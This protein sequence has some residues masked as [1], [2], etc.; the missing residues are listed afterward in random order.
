[1]GGLTSSP[2]IPKPQPQVIYVRQPNAAPTPSPS[3]NTS[4]DNTSND[5]G[6]ESEASNGSVVRRQSLIERERGR[7][8][9]VTTG[10]RGLLNAVSSDAQRKTLLGE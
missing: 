6:S 8:G 7:F 1:M 3:A 5:G 10:F 9:T 2:N 4:A